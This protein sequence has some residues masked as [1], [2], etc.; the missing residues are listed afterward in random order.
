MKAHSTFFLFSIY[1]CLLF[2]NFIRRPVVCVSVDG[3]VACSMTRSASDG[4]SPT[5]FA[6]DFP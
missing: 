2:K 1:F 6:A 5:F 3:H 4:T